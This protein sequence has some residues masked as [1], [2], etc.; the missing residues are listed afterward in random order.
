[1]KRLIQLLIFTYI[2]SFTVI[3]PAPAF[4]QTVDALCSGVGGSGEAYDT[5]AVATIICSGIRVLNFGFFLVAGVFVVMFLFG[6][7]KYATAWGDP[8]G[9]QGAQQTVTSAV[10]G[11]LIC[12]GGATIMLVTGNIVGLDSSFTEGVNPFNKLL[13]GLC[14]FLAV[15]DLDCSGLTRY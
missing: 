3:S 7:Y 11:A 8:K 9:I 6:M 14:K 12:F 4:A 2:L 13:V 15:A 5:P 10:I 1:M